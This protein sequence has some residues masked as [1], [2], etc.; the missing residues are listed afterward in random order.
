MVFKIFQTD[1]GKPV[2]RRGRK[3]SGLREHS[4]MIAEPAGLYYMKPITIKQ[5]VG[6]FVLIQSG[7]R[8]P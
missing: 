7:S 5:A 1:K 3:V 4:P 2:E 6:F 8:F